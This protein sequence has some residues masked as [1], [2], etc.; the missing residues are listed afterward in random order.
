MPYSKLQI[1]WQGSSATLE[2]VET[3][4]GPIRVTFFRIEVA[5]EDVLQLLPAGYELPPQQPVSEPKRQRGGG[6][7]D[8]YHWDLVVAQVLRL[9]ND[10]GWP[11]I[12]SYR[13]FAKKV[14]NACASDGMDQIPSE[15]RVR[16][17]LSL[18]F[19]ACN[20]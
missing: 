5:R 8:L 1:H 13:K 16:E 18:W 6:R 2:D 4:A 9:L 11:E 19:S 12:R 10:E 20:R 15:D 17:K 14:C 3:D 7:P